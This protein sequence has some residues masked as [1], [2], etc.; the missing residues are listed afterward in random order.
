MQ[1]DLQLHLALATQIDGV[2]IIHDDLCTPVEAGAGGFFTPWRHQAFFSRELAQATFLTG[3]E[4]KRFVTWQNHEHCRAYNMLCHTAIKASK[5][6]LNIFVAASFPNED[7]SQDEGGI[8]SWGEASV[9]S[10]LSRWL[11]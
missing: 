7:V 9:I 3:A 11:N 4:H 10:F 2:L 5:L 1:R 6:C 8:L